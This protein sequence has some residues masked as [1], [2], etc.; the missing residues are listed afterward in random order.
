MINIEEEIIDIKKRVI[1]VSRKIDN[2]IYEREITAMMK[3]SEYSLRN[4]I[5]KEEEIY[6][7]EDLK[8]R[9]K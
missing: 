9:Y 8:I 7:I 2:L 4:F 6:K 1:D 5:D 3:L